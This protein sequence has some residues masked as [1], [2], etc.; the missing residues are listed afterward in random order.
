MHHRPTARPL[1]VEV[2]LGCRVQCVHT[3]RLGTVASGSRARELDPER[4][5]NPRDIEA[6]QDS[7]NGT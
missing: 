7:L 5:Q 4:L 1:E 2:T 6:G 3:S